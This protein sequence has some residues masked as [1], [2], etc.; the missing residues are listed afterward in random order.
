MQRIRV[1]V[2]GAGEQHMLQEIVEGAV[3]LDGQMDVMST[4]STTDVP[5]VLLVAAAREEMETLKRGGE[6]LALDRRDDHVNLYVLRLFDRVRGS[7]QLAN[8]IRRL[9]S[10]IMRR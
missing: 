4:D 6:V 3:S 9:A 1:K 8:A 7:A 2:A 5:D 10:H